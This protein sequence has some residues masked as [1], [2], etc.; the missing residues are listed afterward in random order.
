M[1]KK[2]S[3]VFAET[4]VGIFMAAVLALL[5]YFTIVI[6]GVDILVG[7][8]KVPMKVEFAD[9]GGLFDVI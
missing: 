2:R 5:V 4:I 7:H 1:S 9:V 3:D 6:S 8:T